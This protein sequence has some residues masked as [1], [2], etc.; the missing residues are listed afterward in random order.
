MILSQLSI[1]DLPCSLPHPSSIFSH[2]CA[3]LSHSPLPLPP[4]TTHFLS[5]HLNQTLL[6]SFQHTQYLPLLSLPFTYIHLISFL[7]LPLSYNTQPLFPDPFQVQVAKGC[8]LHAGEPSVGFMQIAYEGS[9]LVSFQNTS[10][11]PSPKGGRRAQQVSKLFNQYHVVN[12]RIQA[13]I[14]DACPRFLLGLL[15]A[16]KEDLQRQGQSCFL[17]PRIL[18][19]HSEFAPFPQIQG[20]RGQA[21]EVMMVIGF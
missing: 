8:G 5:L 11:W 21:R 10:W 6:H 15:E 13:S 3:F 1:G 12:L 9:D 20:R 18:T 2:I 4:V 19:L 14:N 16:G 17:F 7:S